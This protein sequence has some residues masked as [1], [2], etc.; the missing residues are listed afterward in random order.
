M[1]YEITHSFTKENTIWERVVVLNIHT[2]NAY[3]NVLEMRSNEKAN[4]P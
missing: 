4:F 1:P 3:R 2:K